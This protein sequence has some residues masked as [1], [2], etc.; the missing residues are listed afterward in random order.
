M[1]ERELFDRWARYYGFDISRNSSGT[2]KDTKVRLMEGAWL[3]R[4]DKAWQD[5]QNGE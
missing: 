3:A 2:L 5:K 4:A 1:T